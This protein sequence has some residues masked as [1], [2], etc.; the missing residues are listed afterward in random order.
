MITVVS[1]PDLFSAVYRDVTYK[2]TSDKSP[3]VGDFTSQINS[4]TEPGILDFPFGFT[5]G[6]PIVR[7]LNPIQGLVAGGFIEISDTD[8]SLYPGVHRIIR[9]KPGDPTTFQIDT[10][11][12]GDDA[13]GLAKNYF[14]DYSIVVNVYV[15]GGLSFQT[16]VQH[17]QDGVFNARLEEEMREFLGSDVL[18]SG[19]TASQIAVNT[20]KAF[21][22]EYAE[23]YLVRGSSG[24]DSVV[25]FDFTGDSANTKVGVNAT[26]PKA[27]IKDGKIVS[28]DGNLDKYIVDNVQAAKFLSN[29]P[30]V[31][32]IGSEE[33]YQ[34]SAIFRQSI[35]LIVDG[36]N[37]TMEANIA[38]L[39]I[40]ATNVVAIS[41]SGVN[42]F[43]NL[44]S[45]KVD[46]DGVIFG[47][48][49]ILVQADTAISLKANTTY[50]ITAMVAI[51]NVKASSTMQLRLDLSGSGFFPSFN[52]EYLPINSASLDYIELRTTITVG[53]ADIIR[54]PHI[55][56][57]DSPGTDV[58]GFSYYIDNW[59]M[60]EASLLYDRRARFYDNL[61][62]LISTD[63]EPI[64]INADR[65]MSIPVGTN[66]LT[67][68]ANTT[69][70]LIDVYNGT[71][72]I[73]EELAFEINDTCVE[74]TRLE[75]MNLRGGIDAFSMKGLIETSMDV[76]Q[77]TFKRLLGPNPGISAP[78]LITTFTDS[79]NLMTINSGWVTKEVTE[80]LEELIQSSEVYIVLDNL[81]SG[82]KDK[83][84]IN[85]TK[86]SFQ[87][88]NSV[89]TLFNIGFTYRL[90]I[91]KIVQKN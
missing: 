33:D 74:K 51:T 66:N 40:P 49:Q 45:A 69:R 29:Q 21:Y 60:E 18:D 23:E 10:E 13:G 16:R 6:S 31:H 85:I 39:S 35:N 75:F 1:R 83:L 47:A 42:P 65:C 89:D 62:A 67:V 15:D 68:P 25:I 27:F 7:I 44:Y 57:L 52:V 79:V 43:S 56:F 46:M 41:Q 72:A 88:S 22:I 17:D 87:I 48:L 8:N 80:W 53:G 24:V 54:N 38:G 70:Y 14:K 36:D 77:Q 19:D 91:D 73:T 64:V 59:T 86:G 82:G 26:V 63:L 20:S 55:M 32:Q 78:Q 11:Y 37:G 50:I 28:A 58:T 90:S 2:F 30:L 81:D 84:L 34:L 76:Q 5:A 61:G 12:V 9:I 3:A 71:N 4:I